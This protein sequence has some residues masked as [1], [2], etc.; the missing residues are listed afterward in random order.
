MRIAPHAKCRSI[1]KGALH[2]AALI[3]LA[4]TLGSFAAHADIVVTVPATTDIWLAGQPSGSS[5]SGYFGT[6]Y[7]PANSPIAISVNG[8]DVLTFSNVVDSPGGVSVDGSCFDTTPDAGVCYTD[9][10]GFSPGPVNGI[11]LAHLPADAL[12]GVFVASGGPSGSTPADLDFT[13]AGGYSF[14]TLSPLLD[15]LF[16]VGDGLTG[17]GT[18]TVQQ[19]TAP[20]GTATLYLAVADSVGSSVGNVGYI[21]ADVSD[22]TSVPEPGTLLSLGTL[23]ALLT[24][25]CKRT[26]K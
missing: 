8:G 5:V 11:S 10:F 24:L 19:F 3:P 12:V 20:A 4:I 7:A 13:G 16:F 23:L 25:R 17:T 22:L 15:Q 2:A 14:L 1:F 18:G 21:T 6:D 9:E 26:G